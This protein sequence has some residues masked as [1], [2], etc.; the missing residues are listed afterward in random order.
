M[1]PPDSDTL[2]LALPSGRDFDNICGQLRDCGFAM[3]ELDAPGLHRI[4]D[5]LGIGIHFDIFKLA[6]ADVGTYVEHGISQLGVMSTELLRESD[7]RVWRPYTFPFGEYPLAL[8][9]PR[10]MNLD[11]LM[12][13]PVVRL[14]T[15]LPTLTRDIFAA[16]GMSIE[17]V[18]VDDSTTACLLG[19]ADGYVDRLISPEEVLRG[20][21]RVLE[22]VGS[23]QLKLIVN[24][25]SYPM[26]REAIDTFI[27]CLSEHEPPAP[28]PIEIPFDHHE[29]W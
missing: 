12:M 26:R 17:V 14:A 29:E 24:R 16:R 1:Q 18:P 28:E 11:V 9:A 20:G 21:F 15:S 13:R 4:E 25:A 3:P 7:T 22:V 8:A 19:L 5:P 27:E 6:A 23:A 10:G 2:R